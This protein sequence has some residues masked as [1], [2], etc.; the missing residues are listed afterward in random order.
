MPRGKRYKSKWGLARFVFNES[1]FWIKYDVEVAE[2]CFMQSIELRQE[3]EKLHERSDFGL[4][5]QQWYET[6]IEELQK[7]EYFE[8]AAF[9]IDLYEQIYGT[10]NTETS[11]EL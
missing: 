4:T 8:Q 9:W 10:G 2:N 3:S 1:I 5:T 11:M 6:F 7:N